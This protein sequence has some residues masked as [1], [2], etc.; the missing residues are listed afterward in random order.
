MVHNDDS[1]VHVYYNYY[2]PGLNLK[3]NKLLWPWV[4]NG[5]IN[6]R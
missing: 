5:L 1:K 4:S 6:G 3:I 2:I